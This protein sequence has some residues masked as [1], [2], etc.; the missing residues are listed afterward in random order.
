[1]GKHTMKYLIE[2]QG[3]LDAL[4]PLFEKLARTGDQAPSVAVDTEFLREK[5]YNAKLC[6]VQLGIGDDQYC[7][8]VLAIEDLTL[9]A[10]LFTNTEI[11]KLLHA[12]RQDMEVI[13]QTMGVLPRPVFDTQLAAAFCGMDLQLG[14][15]ALVAEKLSIE[16]SKS[17]ARTDW[18]RR[19]LSTEQLEYAYEDVEHLKSLK[20]ML[21]DDLQQAGKLS[22]FEEELQ[23]LYDVEKY[24]FAPEQA[25]KR[26]A[27]GNLKLSQQYRLKALATWRETMAQQRDIPR[28]WV[29]RD[30][31]LYDLAIQQPKSVEEIKDL[32]IFGRKSVNRLAPQALEIMANVEVGETPLWRRA[33]PLDKAQ[34]ALVSN[35][36]SKLKGLAQEHSIAQGLLGTR[37]DLESLFRYRESKKLLNGWRKNLVGKPLLEIAK[38][39]G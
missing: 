20:D 4:A 37:R 14:H 11:T 28:S 31:K 3:Q 21:T 23:D 6:L 36:M 8:D 38:S 2:E 7:V 26:L 13:W 27:G 19:P 10:E 1:M 39:Q 16:L 30:D 25:Y 15:T 17:Q 18:T 22:W 29:I 34:K 5:T 24:E 32:G 12:A 35:M 33:D 9:I